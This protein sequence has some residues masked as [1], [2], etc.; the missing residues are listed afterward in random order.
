MVSQNEDE[1]NFHIYYQ[2]PDRAQHP[3]IWGCTAP[4]HP[5]EGEGRERRR[6]RMG[7]SV[8]AWIFVCVCVPADG[9]TFAC[10]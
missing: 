1:R 7:V 2:V 9:Y 8:T 4:L 6:I 3:G 5:R 10:A